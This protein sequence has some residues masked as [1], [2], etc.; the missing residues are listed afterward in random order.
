MQIFPRVRS[1]SASDA[2]QKH[3]LGR[4]AAHRCSEIDEANKTQFC[5]LTSVVDDLVSLPELIRPVFNFVQTEKKR[6][7]SRKAVGTNCAMLA[8]ITPFQ[9]ID[10]DIKISFVTRHSDMSGAD[11][12]KMMANDQQH[13]QDIFQYA[14]QLPMKSKFPSELLV[15]DV[16]NDF[17]EDRATK[18]GSRLLKFK[19]MGGLDNRTGRPMFQGSTGCYA[20][21]V[22]E[23]KI[24][25]FLHVSGESV[26]IDESWGLTNRHALR[27][28]HDDWAACLVLK[29]MPDIKLASLFDS[30][31]RQGPH[32]ITN[33]NGKP[34]ELLAQAQ[35]VHAAWAQRRHEHDSR[36]S[37]TS[38][39]AKSLDE[40]RRADAKQRMSK[41][42]VA[43]ERALA[44]KRARTTQVLA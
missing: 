41:A 35:A 3:P 5:C 34:K 25:K 42:K 43:A 1:Q 19:G 10:Q 33:Y 39:I 18:A 38:D 31:A 23:G 24:T 14:L 2:F 13:L 15:V 17:L 11:I 27:D 6:L 26:D 44:K 28:N 16:M 30:K 12:I 36:G 40:Q 37:I 21:T 29:P 32:R 7:E 8:A 20:L 4:R 22:T 9:G